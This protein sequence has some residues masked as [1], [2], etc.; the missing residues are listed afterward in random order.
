MTHS[1]LDELSFF[2]RNEKDLWSEIQ[3]ENKQLKPGKACIDKIL[4]YSRA[5]SVRKSEN[6]DQLEMILN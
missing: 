2:S 6:L 5:L 3:P 1:T 4:A